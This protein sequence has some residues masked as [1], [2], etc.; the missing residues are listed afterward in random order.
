M[1]KLYYK[2]VA[3]NPFFALLAVDLNGVLYYA[4]VGHS[5]TTLIN[6]MAQDFSKLKAYKLSSVI[7]KENDLIVNTF[8][9]F[10]Q[11]IDNPKLID[12]FNLQ[13]RLIFGTS[14]QQL[15]W[16]KLLEIPCGSVTDYGSLAHKLGKPNGSRVIGNCVG[17]NRIALIIPCHR[18]IA[19]SQKITGYRYGIDIKQYLLKRELCDNYIKLIK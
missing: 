2:V 11:I 8:N 14:L 5:T 13:F 4:S 15:V 18:V 9:K 7:P 3:G 16:K 10:S 1:E 19:K 6:L 12:E 17:A